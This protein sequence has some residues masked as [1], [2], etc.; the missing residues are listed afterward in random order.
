MPWHFYRILVLLIAILR[1]REAWQG[2]K[3]AEKDMENAIKEINKN[4][5]LKEKADAK[6]LKHV[7]SHLLSKR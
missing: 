6:R 1:G 7:E 2:V 3:A 5:R 4:W